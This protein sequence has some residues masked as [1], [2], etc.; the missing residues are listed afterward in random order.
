MRTDFGAE[1]VKSINAIFE[2]Y[3]ETMDIVQDG[4]LTLF[5]LDKQLSILRW[6][7]ARMNEN[8]EDFKILIDGR[9]QRKAE[10]LQRDREEAKEKVSQ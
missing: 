4:E 8:L 2:S 3:N 6:A 5:D 10:K 7:E 9:K 1:A